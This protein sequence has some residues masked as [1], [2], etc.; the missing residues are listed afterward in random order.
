MDF[1]VRK[2]VESFQ[3]G[4][5]S[6]LLTLGKHHFGSSFFPFSSLPQVMSKFIDY[7][8]PESL[9]LQDDSGN[10]LFHYAVACLDDNSIYK[11]IVKGANLVPTPSSLDHSSRLTFFLLT[12]VQERGGSFRRGGGGERRRGEEAE[13][14]R[15]HFQLQEFWPIQVH[16]DKEAAAAGGH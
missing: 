14:K 4:G 8:G 12:D 2:K 13:A 7:L 3:M 5:R 10:T 1:R 15:H 11:M 9:R 16:R 6:D